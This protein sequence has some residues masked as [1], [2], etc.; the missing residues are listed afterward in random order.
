MAKNI[1]VALVLVL[2]SHQSA[3]A[4]DNITVGV[5]YGQDYPGL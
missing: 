4:T 3:F 5:V 2:V 1:V